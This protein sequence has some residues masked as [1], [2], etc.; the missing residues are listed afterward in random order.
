MDEFS[1]LLKSSE[2]DILNTW[3]ALGE[4]T[5]NKNTKVYT[6]GSVARVDASDGDG[7]SSS[8]LHNKIIYIQEDYKVDNKTKFIIHWDELSID[9]VT[10][11]H[12][13]VQGIQLPYFGILP[14]RWNGSF[15][16]DNSFLPYQGQDE[17]AA[18]SLAAYGG[19]N[20]SDDEL[21][22]ILT[23]IG[24]PFANF[25]DVEYSKEQIVKYM[26]R[27]AMQR[28]FTF[29]PIVKEE[30]YGNISSG[31]S[32]SIEFPENAYGCVPY[33]CVPGGSIGGGGQ[34]M[35]PFAFFGE[36]QM[37]MGR[38]GTVSSRYGGGLRYRNKMVPGYVGTADSQSNIVDALASQQGMLNVF[39]REK[40]RKVKHDGKLYAEGFSTIGGNLNI[41]WLCWSP[42]WDDIDMDD[43]EPIARPM[44]R[45]EVLRNFVILR[46]LVKADI[47]GQ[48]DP[49]ILKEMRTEIETDLKPIINS[50]GITGTLAVQRGSGN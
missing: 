32:F 13:A 23:V 38:M 12:A 47:S 30:G 27:P 16:K 33:Y 42:N 10:G 3:A 46:S 4:I 48:L 36:R 39:R 41:K 45:S 40:Y 28:Y 18:Q 7:L 37:S 6:R 21:E 31:N 43:L 24:F 34:S 1:Y 8:P 20:I 14:A 19:I 11:I 49:S 50:I 35:N 22:T 5:V 9:D 15:I 29:R 44:A 17:N 25:D 26:I 2:D